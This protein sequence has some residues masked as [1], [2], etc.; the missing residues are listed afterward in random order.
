MAPSSTSSVTQKPTPIVTPTHIARLIIG[1]PIQDFVTILGKPT[2]VTPANPNKVY[3]FQP[4][5]AD[6]NQYHYQVIVGKGKDGQ[7]HITEFTEDG[8]TNIISDKIGGLSLSFASQYKIESCL[9]Q[10]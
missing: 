9:D 6:E 2:K 7:E 5:P 8:V 1:A 4:N 10:Q 3:Y